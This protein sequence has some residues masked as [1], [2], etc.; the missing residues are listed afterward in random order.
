MG[1]L[2]AHFEKI[3][4]GTRILAGLM[5]MFHGLQKILGLFGGT[6]DGTPPFIQYGAGGIE[7]IGGALVAIGLFAAPAAFLSSGTMAVAY[8]MAHQPKGLFPIENGG[9]LAILYCWI[10]LM[11]AARGAGIWSVDAS[12]DSGTST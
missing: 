5:F 7:L 9:E 12:R 2:S 1:F 4:A 10:F 8:F 3:Y 11:I 6:P